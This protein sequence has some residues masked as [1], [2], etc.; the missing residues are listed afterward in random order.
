MPRPA[1]G[2]V[3]ERRR[4]DHTIFA[5]RFRAYGKREYVTLGTETEGWS[6]ARAEAELRH[7]LADVERG[8][9][10]PSRLLPVEAPS[11]VPTFH[12]FASEWLASRKGELR[13]RS[14]EDYKWAL[15]YHLLPYF[16]DHVLTEITIEEV[17][18]YRAAKLDEGKLAANTLN[19]TLVRLG[20]ILEVAVEYGHI[21][22][23]PAKGKRRRVKA[24]E[25]KRTGSSPS[26]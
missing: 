11:E 25:P 10:K 18:R 14:F 1:T 6:R 13:S 17:D 26:S 12:V 8:I 2:S 16:K 15:T 20:S 3:A 21:D 9:W 24:T 5:L 7:T 22:R 4:K 19:K 23:N